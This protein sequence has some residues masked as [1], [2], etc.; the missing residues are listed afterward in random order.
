MDS[1]QDMSCCRDNQKVKYTADSFG[2]K[3]LTWWNSQSRTLCQEVI[4]G[5][6]WD[7]FK[8]AS[9]LTDEAFRNGSIKKNLEKRG[10]RGEP[11]KDRNEKDDNKRTKTGNAFATTANHVRREYI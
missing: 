9:T 11:S 1:V 2:G 4:V 7:N 3:A 8:I 6:S 10:N 5:M